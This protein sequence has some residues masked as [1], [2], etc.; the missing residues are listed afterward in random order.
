[1]LVLSR[2]LEEKIVLPGLNV[3]LQV[4][5]IKRGAVRLG[6]SAPPEVTVLRAELP[7]RAAECGRTAPRPESAAAPPR[8]GR[9]EQLV[10]RRLH[11]TRVG[12]AQAR[13][14]LRAGRA[15]EALLLLGKIDEDARLLE[16]RLGS[17]RAPTPP[18][19]RGKALVVDDDRNTSALLA[20]CLR[21]AGLDVE[22]AGD[23]LDA[24]DYLRTNTRPDVLLLDM[25]MPRC[26][27]PATL[28]AI[29]RNPAYSDLKVFGLSG[30]ARDEFDI[31]TGPDGLN[32][33]FQKPIDPGALLR[34]LDRELGT[35]VNRLRPATAPTAR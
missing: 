1:M 26:D 28:R 21:L 25:V 22:T 16:Q 5:A 27:G 13:R 35:P 17:A 18:P 19:A 34:D 24:L 30:H 11:V 29:R 31:A 6:I 12:L 32:G 9:V 8:P 10:R 20:E 14:H 4:I 3:T 7:D 15:E 2:R 33:W 23:G